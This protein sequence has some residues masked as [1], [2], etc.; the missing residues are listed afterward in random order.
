MCV[1]LLVDEIERTDAIDFEPS[2]KIKMAAIELFNMYAMD[3][4][5]GRD[6]FR[7]TSPIDFKFGYDVIPP[8]ERTLLIL[9]H[10]PACNKMA[11]I[12]LLKYIL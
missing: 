8:K 11:V 1:L 9:G 12:K 3:T 10:H 4:T 7:T 6:I 5:C 2:V